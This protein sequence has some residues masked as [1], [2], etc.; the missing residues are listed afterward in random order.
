M[1]SVFTPL[2]MEDPYLGGVYHN[3]FPYLESY[4]A[5]QQS[6]GLVWLIP[7]FV[8]RRETCVLSLFVNE[9]VWLF[10]CLSS[11]QMLLHNIH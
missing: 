3:S 8:L 4:V 9:R 11:P 2:N 1:Q 6:S 7:L 5:T 10:I